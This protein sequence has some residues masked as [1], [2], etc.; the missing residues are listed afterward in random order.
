MDTASG[1]TQTSFFVLD[2][3]TNE[4]G[5]PLPPELD[6]G[7]YGSVE[8]NETRVSSNKSSIFVGR[9]KCFFDGGVA[10]NVIVVSSSTMIFIFNYG[11]L[12]SSMS[13]DSVRVP[14]SINKFSV[15]VT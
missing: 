10:S 6:F 14:Q 11:N 13:G 3:I 2:V 7:T 4:F 5:F 9:G 15:T 12:F 1:F 8:S